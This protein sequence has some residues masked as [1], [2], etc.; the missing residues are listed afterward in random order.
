[1]ATKMD[2][3]TPCC[4]IA[5]SLTICKQC[6]E[7]SQCNILFN[8]YLDKQHVA[9]LDCSVNDCERQIQVHVLYVKPAFREQGIAR[10][11][12][13]FVHADFPGMEIRFQQ[14]T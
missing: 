1:M 5:D 8:A 6:S 7:T 11:L 4:N 12:L 9:A 13:N 3:S 10:A 2:T 14:G